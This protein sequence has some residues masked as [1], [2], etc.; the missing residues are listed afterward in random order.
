MAGVLAPI[1]REYDVALSVVRGFVSVS[2]AHEIAEL[3]SQIEKPIFG[4]YLGDHDPSGLDL[5]RDLQRK[6]DRYS[7]HRFEWERLA[8]LPDDFSAFNLFPLR[9]KGTD[10]RTRQFRSR[11]FDQCA[12]LDAIPPSELRH[13]VESAIVQHIPTAEW[14]RLRQ[15]EALEREQWQALLAALN[16][17]ESASS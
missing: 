15:I 2:F 17:Q 8:V 5:E 13:R 1:T 11:G 6:L 9:P 12:E 7:E 4:Y 16:P 14:E 10:S 3:W